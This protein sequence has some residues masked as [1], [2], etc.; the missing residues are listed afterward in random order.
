MKGDTMQNAVS[1][2]NITKVV[3]EIET[4]NFFQ[5]TGSEDESSI[6]GYEM[7]PTKEGN[8]GSE[9]VYSAK[10]TPWGVTLYAYDGSP[11]VRYKTKEAKK[12]DSDRKVI[13]EELDYLSQAL[14]EFF[15]E[16]QTPD[17][18]DGE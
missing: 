9:G 8:V 1:N 17:W 6:C 15:G 11:V 5:A 12:T 18:D 16:D 14:N 3:S 10:V 7:V 2:T 13:I 4:V